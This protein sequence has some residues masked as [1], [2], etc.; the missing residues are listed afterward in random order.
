M[1]SGSKLFLYLPFWLITIG[2]V[3]GALADRLDE[4][5]LQLPAPIM[6][7]FNMYRCNNELQM[8]EGVLVEE[9]RRLQK[10]L[11]DAL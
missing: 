11:I 9:C 3:V 10:Q 1:N 5:A 2:T 6:L 8:N 7:P 4:N